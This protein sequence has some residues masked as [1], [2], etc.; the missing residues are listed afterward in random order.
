M[1]LR[2]ALLLV[3]PD[4]LMRARVLSGCQPRGVRCRIDSPETRHAMRATG[5]PL[6]YLTV[7]LSAAFSAENGCTGG[8]PGATAKKWRGRV[9]T[10]PSSLARLGG[11]RAALARSKMSLSTAASAGGS[12]TQS[13]YVERYGH[14]LYRN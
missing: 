10:A 8:K 12:V 5:A 7:S 2:R 9:A 11:A 1:S 3:R 4:V 6:P 14:A 13:V